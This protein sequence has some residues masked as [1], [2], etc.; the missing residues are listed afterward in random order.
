M[1]LWTELSR[2]DVVKV[3]LAYLAFAW[4]I[5]QVAAT[6]LPAFGGP[7]WILRAVIVAFVLGFPIALV[8]AWKYELTSE[9]VQRD[10]GLAPAATPG[11]YGRGLDL[12]IIGFLVLALSVVI[13]DQ[14]LIDGGSAPGIDSIAVLPLDNV[15]GDSD[16]EYFVDGMTDALI[17]SL[18][19]IGALKVVSRT[20]AMRYK[21]SGLSLPEIAM[22]LGV[23]AV[24][25][26]S[27]SYLG[28]RIRITA[29][30]I[31]ATSDRN[32]WAQSY[33]RD[34][35]DVLTLQND[36][37]LD[38]AREVS[39]AVTPEERTRLLTSR[40]VNPETYEAYLRGMYYLNGSTAEDVETGLRF[41]QEAVDRDPG[42]PLAYAGLALGYATIAHSIAP[43]EGTWQSARAAAQR[44]INLDPDLAEAHLALGNVKLYFEWDFEGAEQALLRAIEINPSLA[45]SHYHYAWYLCLVG[46]LD[47]AI[48][49]HIRARDLDPLTP[50]HTAWL[51]SLYSYRGDFDLAIETAERALELNPDMPAARIVR[52]IAYLGQGRFEEAVRAHEELVALAP[53]WGGLLAVTYARTGDEPRARE[54]LAELEERY[55]NE[56]SGWLSRDIAIG[57][58]A[59]GQSEQAARW[60][61]QPPYHAW[62]PWVAVD[63]LIVPL[64]RDEPRYQELMTQLDLP[65][66][67]CCYPYGLFA[68]PRED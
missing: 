64:L 57:Y 30:L 22:R 60:L 19:R 48:A 63:P 43:P 5:I 16:Q 67:S 46:R 29:Q 13:V 28:G 9:G 50:L 26:G 55:N 56:P 38:I 47:E 21:D 25:E 65:K 51:G 62:V 8:L 42:D 44:A 37:A 15:S 32:L 17:T 24:L 39:I 35:E 66:E 6:V 14:Y 61:A 11:R 40:R 4:L 58:A 52:V 68:T 53:L 23:R 36:L 27:V 10:D 33:D 3:G 41:L 7:V 12:A 31:D 2:R 54:V 49:E 18:A 59:L 1:S 20:S 34:V 45:M